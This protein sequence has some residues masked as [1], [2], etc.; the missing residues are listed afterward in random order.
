MIAIV[1]CMRQVCTHYC[2]RPSSYNRAKGNPINL[3]ILGNPFEMKREAERNKVCE[4]YAK[5]LWERMLI[6]KTVVESLMSIPPNASLGCFCHPKACH[7]DSIKSAAEWLRNTPG[8][9]E[10]LNQTTYQPD[11][12]E[13]QSRNLPT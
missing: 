2:G 13:N 6:D 10:F 1:N 5:Y 8:G 11:G 4:K 9:Q 3:S 7:C 12:Q